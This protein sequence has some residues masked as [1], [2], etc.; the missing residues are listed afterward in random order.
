MCDS[1]LE[2]GGG[3]CPLL[4]INYVFCSITWRRTHP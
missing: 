2:R 1:P 4:G 3:V